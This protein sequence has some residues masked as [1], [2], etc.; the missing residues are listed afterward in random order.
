MGYSLVVDV[1]DRKKHLL[2]VKA[3]YVM[4]K[5]PLDEILHHV[6]VNRAFKSQVSY[7]F[8]VRR[9]DKISVRMEVKHSNQV[10]VFELIVYVNFL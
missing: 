1:F 5:V 4:A 10:W 8:T 6:S 2:E 9:I 3:C 7:R